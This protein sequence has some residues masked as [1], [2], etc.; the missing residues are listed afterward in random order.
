MRPDDKICLHSHLA[1][2]VSKL[3][4]PL[5]MTNGVFDV[6]HRG[7]VSYLNRAAELGA[8]LLVAVNT[9]RSVRTLGKGSGRPLNSELDRAYVLAGLSS[10]DIVTFFDTRTPVELIQAIKP[11]VYV[12]GGDYDME[13]LEETRVVRGWGGQA[14]AIP[15]VDGFSTTALVQRIRQPLRKAV[16]LDRD[17]VINKDKGYVGRW[18]DFEFIPGA[19]EGMRLLQ[20]AGYTLVVVTNQSGLARGYYVEAQYQALTQQMLA[21]IKQG[22]VELARIYHCPHHPEGVVPELTIIC[23]CRKPAP[24]L[25]VKAALELNLSLPDCML[26]GDKSSDIQAARAAGVGKAYVVSSDNPENLANP[27]HADGNFDNL[28]A[29]AQYLTRNHQQEVS[30]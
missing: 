7:H 18:E 14:V 27:T 12:K 28:L 21:A 11:D 16:F 5:V 20:K 22:G 8:S 9:D 2:R 13:T 19:I 24:G 15:L 29:C 10:V 23:D 30:T 3:G 6:L 1:E 17:G 26:I 25:L 4:R